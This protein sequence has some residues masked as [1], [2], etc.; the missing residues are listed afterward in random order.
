MKFGGLIILT[1][2]FFFLFAKLEAAGGACMR[3]APSCIS[4]ELLLRD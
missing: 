2:V 3:G 1:C 4:E